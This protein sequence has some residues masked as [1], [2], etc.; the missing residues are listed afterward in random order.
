MPTAD[1]VHKN[2]AEI[3]GRWATT[4]E[5]IHAELEGKTRQYF[6]VTS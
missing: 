4:Q 6:L 3:S 5:I 2:W 1:L